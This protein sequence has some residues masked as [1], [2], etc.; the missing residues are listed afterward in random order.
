MAGSPTPPLI[1]E[2]F[3]SGAG[4]AYITNPIPVA[5]QISVKA[6]AASYTDGFPPLTMT[7][8][9]SGGVNPYGQDVNGILFA[10]TANIAALTGGQQYT[11]NSTYATAN[12]GYAL[13]A[14]LGMANG[15]GFWLNQ[16][17][18]NSNDPD[19]TAAATSGW[20]PLASYGVTTVSGLTNA[21]IT[22]SAVQAAM[23]VITLAGALTGN[24]QIIFPP[25]TK[26]WLII[27]NATLGAYSITCKTASGTGVIVPA[28]E[29]QIR[30]DGTN[31]IN[32]F[33]LTGSFTPTW[34]GFSSAPSSTAT[35]SV[36]GN[37]ATL[38]G[39]FTGT[40]NATT[41][42]LTNLPVEIVP[43]SSTLAN[44]EVP[45]ILEDNSIGSQPGVAIINTAGAAG[46]IIT[47]YRQSANTSTG[48]IS[49]GANSFTASGTKGLAGSIMWP[50]I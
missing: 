19:T 14:I 13:G 44:L 22:L 29:T 10:A 37:I 50:I 18:G 24:V 41:M 25:W 11:F 9:A 2:A 35:F 6:G 48:V 23:P 3:G 15:A 36:N 28:G 40:S 42:T 1:Q 21:N 8:P 12:G 32:G 38:N 39:I 43:V 27:N 46:G 20:V 17:A 47:F 5:S 30:G 49:A 34:T 33:Y 7:S 26:Q 4:S 16:T 45:C 31:I